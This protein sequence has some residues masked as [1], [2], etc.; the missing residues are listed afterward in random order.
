K[1]AVRLD[2]DRQLFPFATPTELREHIEEAVAQ[3]FLPEGG[4]LLSA[5]CGP[6]VPLNNI[7]AIC[8]ILKELGC[9]AI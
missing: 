6:D 4:L 7:A 9:R 2:L 1:V 8:E 3:L 5:E